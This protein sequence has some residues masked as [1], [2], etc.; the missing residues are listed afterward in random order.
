MEGVQSKQKKENQFFLSLSLS[1]CKNLYLSAFQYPP[2]FFVFSTTSAWS[3]DNIYT[4]ICFFVLFRIKKRVLLEPLL[5][6]LLKKQKGK[7]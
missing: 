5:F 1:A 3:P 4:F 2:P 7:K 6:F